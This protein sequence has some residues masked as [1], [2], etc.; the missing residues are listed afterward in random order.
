MPKDPEN[1]IHKI[2]TLE[3]RYI[4]LKETHNILYILKV[5][6]Q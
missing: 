5:W 2:K 6:C 1:K 3:T 4:Y